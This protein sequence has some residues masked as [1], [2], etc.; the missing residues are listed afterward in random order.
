MS[1]KFQRGIF[2][3]SSLNLFFVVA[4]AAK[5]TVPTHFQETLQN[6]IVQN[7]NKT[8][9]NS[10]VRSHGF[11]ICGSNVLFRNAEFQTIPGRCGWEDVVEHVHSMFD[12]A[13]I[14][15][16][17]LDKKCA[18]ILANWLIESGGERPG[19]HPPDISAIS[20]EPQLFTRL[21]DHLFREYVSFLYI[22]I[23]LRAF[24]NT[25]LPSVYVLVHIN[26]HNYI[27][28]S[29]NSLDHRHLKSSPY[30]LYIVMMISPSF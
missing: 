4:I 22:Y 6:S 3:I 5:D 14:H 18:L 25:N 10:D 11:K 28:S 17:I 19:G 13:D 1:W 16:E 8:R 9:I 29:Q 26:I 23:F 24:S 30:V 15:S 2:F 20:T 12:Y 21:V 7:Q 27:I